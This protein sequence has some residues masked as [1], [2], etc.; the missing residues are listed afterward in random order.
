MASCNFLHC[1]S[2][3]LQFRSKNQIITLNSVVPSD[4]GKYRCEISNP[5]GMIHHTY[6]LDVAGMRNVVSS[7]EKG[8]LVVG[9][10]E[11]TAILVWQL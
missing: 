8:I 6:E 7:S 11:L 4:I 5:Y 2:L 10:F 1:L 9:C 3:V